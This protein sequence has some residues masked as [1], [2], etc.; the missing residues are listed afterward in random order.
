MQIVKLNFFKNYKIIYLTIFL[1][2][3]PSGLILKNFINNSIYFM[4]KEYK[5]IKK[6]VNKIASKNKLGDKNI[7]FTITNG[8][9]MS[10]NM[11]DLDLC[12]EDICW[13]YKNLN[14][15]KK[16]KNKNNININE[17]SNQSYLY[18]GI[19]AY[20]WNEIVWISKST[21]RTLGVNEGFLG[22]IIGHE[23]SHILFNNHISD[24]L[25]LSTKMR[26]LEILESN[27][28]KKKDLELNEKNLLE[29]EISRLSE[30]QAD[31]NSSKFLTYMTQFERLETETDPKSSHPGYLER[32]SSLNKFISRYEIE[33]NLEINKTN[34]WKWRFNRDLNILIFIP[35][36]N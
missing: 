17:L 29:M 9:Y 30:S 24:S 15:F 19:E 28:S 34:K 13:Y 21:F 32:I 2:S 36:K 3:I 7:S 16:Y 14:P 5:L 27:K 18:G 10:R 22:C 20:A 1:I 25:K 26:E 11:K 31:N 33:S 8:N 35:I 6:I 23:F 4:P 12:K